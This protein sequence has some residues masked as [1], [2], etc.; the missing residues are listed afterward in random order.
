MSAGEV[1]CGVCGRVGRASPVDPACLGARLLPTFEALP[2][3]WTLVLGDPPLSLVFRAVRS[4]SRGAPP[5]C[6]TRLT[7]L[8][9]LNE[10]CTEVRRW[11]RELSILT[12][13]PNLRASS[14]LTVV[15]TA[16]RPVSP[17]VDRRPAM[18][19]APR[20]RTK[21]GCTAS[22]HDGRCRSGN[23]ADAIRRA[24]APAACRKSAS[25]SRTSDSRR[26]RRG[27]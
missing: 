5:S 13:L 12:G 6:L 4:T 21:S 16:A 22:R 24:P 19:Q 10:L 7:S 23:R 18:L 8:D 26:D 2:A 17:F 20:R 25:S 3:G 9:E 11:R 14:F 1:A 15:W 27:S